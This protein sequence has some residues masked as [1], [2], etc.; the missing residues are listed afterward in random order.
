[1]AS[2][3]YSHICLGG[4]WEWDYS[5]RSNFTRLYFDAVWYNYSF[6]L[7]ILLNFIFTLFNNLIVRMLRVAA[8]I[9]VL[10]FT[11]KW[12]IF[13]S[14]PFRLP[15][16]KLLC[17]MDKKHRSVFFNV[18]CNMFWQTKDLFLPN[19]ICLWILKITSHRDCHDILNDHY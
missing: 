13:H 17:R 11:S 4:G 19:E 10:C 16:G 18:F 1:M 2:L 6:R 5:W 15:R 7:L 12:K 9:R 3:I 14:C 8:I